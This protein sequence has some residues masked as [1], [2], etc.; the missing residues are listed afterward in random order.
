[1]FLVLWS[2]TIA[3]TVGGYEEDMNFLTVIPIS[4]T[5]VLPISPDIPY[6]Q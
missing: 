5:E 4:E 3:E 2:T 6:F 1:M